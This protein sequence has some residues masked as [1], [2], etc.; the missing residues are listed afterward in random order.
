M[1]KVYIAGIT[2][3]M[4][5]AIADSIQSSS[6]LQLVAGVSAEAVIRAFA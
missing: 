5:A 3:W 6:D 4:G 2:G 1:I